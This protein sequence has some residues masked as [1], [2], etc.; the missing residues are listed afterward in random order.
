MK[1]TTTRSCCFTAIT[2]AMLSAFVLEA[3][4]Q[5]DLEPA[6]R[7]TDRAVSSATTRKITD[8]MRIPRKVSI[9]FAPDDETAAPASSDERFF[10]RAITFTG[11]RTFTSHEL[12]YITRKY[13]GREIT[14]ADMNALAHEIEMEYLKRG[15]VSVVFVP[16]QDITDETLRLQVMEPDT[17]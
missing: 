15:I 5:P 14:S 13:S 10:V 2:I 6:T 7:E 11:M 9:D 12:S 3:C 16:P 17:Q 4:A 8:K 1:S